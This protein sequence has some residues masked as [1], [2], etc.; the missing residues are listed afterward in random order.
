MLMF[1]RAI[2]FFFRVIDLLIIV[3][4]AGSFF[5]RPGDQIYRLYMGICSLTDPILAPCRMLL[6]RIGFGRGMVD[7][8]PVLAIILLSVIQTIL[9]MV[10]RLF[11]F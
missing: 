8:S 7:F 3:R 9:G 1:V 11:Y 5:V 6:N 10:V 2:D 4:C